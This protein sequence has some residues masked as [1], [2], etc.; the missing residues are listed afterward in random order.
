MLTYTN[1][2]NY[3]L[4]S[5]A[6]VMVQGCVAYVDPYQ[7]TV[8]HTSSQN[9]VEER[10]PFYGFDVFYDYYDRPYYVDS[11]RRVIYVE[12]KYYPYVKSHYQYRKTGYGRHVEKQ[13]DDR[14]DNYL[15]DQPRVIDKQDDDR[16]DT[17]PHNQLK[18]IEK[19]DDTRRDTYT[20]DQPRVI[21]KHDD[22]RERGNPNDISKP[23]HVDNSNDKHDDNARKGN[24][25][26]F[27]KPD[28]V[29]NSNVNH[30]KDTEDKKNGANSN[31]SGRFKHN[32]DDSNNNHSND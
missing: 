32:T 13:D 23:N 11:Y 24:P 31:N 20:H 21:D 2:K 4:L 16:R 9:F 14:R 28:H 8:V 7:D 6:G 22:N 5:V 3:L 30:S 26:N 18:V 25:N 1:S 12:T 29:D 27:S 19:Q 15:H 10:P 17:Y